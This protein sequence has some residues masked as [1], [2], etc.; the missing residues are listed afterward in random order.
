MPASESADPRKRGL[1]F[2]VD[3]AT[4]GFRARKLG[5]SA[6]DTEIVCLTCNVLAADPQEWISA[7]LTVQRYDR[8]IGSLRIAFRL[9]PSFPRAGHLLL[10]RDKVT[11]G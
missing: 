4:D 8:F 1:R 11:P 6:S 5:K 3:K 2:A 9:A 7:T 10:Q